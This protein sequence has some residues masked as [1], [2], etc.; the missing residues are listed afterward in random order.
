MDSQFP[1][2]PYHNYMVNGTLMS[3]FTIGSPD[4]GRFVFQAQP[5]MRESERPQ[6]LIKACLFDSLGKPL[7]KMD[8]GRVTDNQGDSKVRKTKTGLSIRTADGESLF[9]IETIA[10]RNTYFTRFSGT[11]YDERGNL[12]AKGAGRD[13]TIHVDFLPAETE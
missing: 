8:R 2:S 3:G 7:L 13:F 6:P 5:V 1:I 4:R 10:F 9:A 11:L 12:I